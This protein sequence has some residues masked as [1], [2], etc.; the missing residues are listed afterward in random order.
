MMPLLLSLVIG[1]RGEE[2]EEEKEDEGVRL[3]A[4]QDGG[5]V[6]RSKRQ[7]SAN[8]LISR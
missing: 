4:G 3:L 2:E 1:L 5:H 7:T 8:M 6:L